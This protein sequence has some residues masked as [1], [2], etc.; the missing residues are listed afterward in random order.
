[1]CALCPEDARRENLGDRCRGHGVDSQL[2]RWRS[3]VHPKCH[4]KWRRIYEAKECPCG[5]GNPDYVF[6]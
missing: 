6:V 3:T 4:G 1:M 5:R 2:T